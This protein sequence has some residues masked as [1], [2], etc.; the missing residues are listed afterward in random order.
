MHVQMVTFRLNGVTEEQYHEVC[1][2]QAEAFAALPGLLAKV[3]LRDP[4]SGTYGG[5]Y[6][7]QDRAAFEAYLASDLFAAV[8]SD[9]ALA[10][11]NSRDYG[12]FDD[13]TQLTQPE[14][15]LV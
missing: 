13:L 6:L 5:I 1:K 14:V 15:A 12:V 3:W 7:W 10:D 11:V 8:K 2:G 4:D 9:K